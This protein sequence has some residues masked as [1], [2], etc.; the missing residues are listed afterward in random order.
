[1][2]V[3]DPGWI[4][5]EPSWVCPEC[6]FDYDACVARDAGGVVRS[7]AR[8]YRI[9]LTR[10]LPGEDL[11]SLVRARP[12]TGGWSALEYACHVRDAL[13]L[14]DF[15]ITKVLE[16]DR[17]VLA[18]MNRDGL[19]I[20]QDYN[21]QDRARVTEELASAAEGLATRLESVPDDGWARVGLR[22]GWEMSVDWMAHNAVHEG[23]HHLVD[24]ARAL[25]TA[26]GR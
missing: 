22:D 19:A 1:V 13:A 10:G 15:R 17:P 6:G 18:A 26:R 20:E 11:D 9:P 5:P 16:N 3:V 21:G 25:R 7:F 14:Y 2:T 8:R 24:V 4:R 23:E 12:P